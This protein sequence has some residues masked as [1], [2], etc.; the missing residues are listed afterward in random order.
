MDVEMADA[1]HVVDENLRGEFNRTTLVTIV[2]IRV[3]T[4]SAATYTLVYAFLKKHKHVKVARS[5]KRAVKSVVVLREPADS[6][7]PSLEDIVKH[8][9][10]FSETAKS[11]PASA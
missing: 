6:S 9:K 7:A 10:S 3:D 2:E 5:F 4:N 8:W 11:P 1:P